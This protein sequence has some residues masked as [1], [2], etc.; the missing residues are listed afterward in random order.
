MI[1]TGK[2]PISVMTFLAI[3]SISLVVNLPGLAV[4]PMLGSLSKIFPE[5]TQ[6]EKQLLTVLPNLAIIPFVFLS[7][8]LSLSRHKIGVVVTAL[9]IFTACSIAYLF[10]N[11][12]IALIAISCL[13]GCGAGLIIPFSKGLISDTFKGTYRMDKMGLV[14]GISNTSLVAATFAVGWLSHGNW[15]LPFVVYLVCLVP[16]LLSFWLR[17]I[18]RDELI[19][20]TAASTS[21]T[22]ATNVA[23]GGKAAAT[24]S[25]A[26]ALQAPLPKP[27]KGGLYLGRIWALIGVYAFITF[28]TVSV[29]YFCPFLAEKKDWSST[30]TGTITSLYY[31]FILI[32]GFS[33][34]W[35]VKILKRGTFVYAAIFM[36]VGLALFAF[37]QYAWALCVGASLAGLG[38]GLCQPL[39]YDKASRAVTSDSKSTLALALVLSSNY[40]AIVLTPLIIDGLRKLLHAHSQGTFAF[41]LCFVLLMAY[42]VITLICRK[43]FAFAVNKSYY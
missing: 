6:L 9:I 29:S 2:A 28:A 12:M 5:T 27:T 10:A 22:T 15:H 3:L 11:S 16:L 7:G 32:P 41:I 42:T 37:C 35:I 17:G 38:Y 40:I 1:Q 33:I 13:L 30:L 18:P 24:T 43:K 4:T 14:S 8:K 25:P 21:T 23:S 20:A 19:P 39:I 36:T 26:A 31:L 34:S